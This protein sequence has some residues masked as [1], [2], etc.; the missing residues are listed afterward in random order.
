MLKKEVSLASIYSPTAEINM[1]TIQQNNQANL[2]IETEIKTNNKKRPKFLSI[3]LILKM[4][5]TSFTLLKYLFDGQIVLQHAL[6]TAPS[7]SLP[8]LT[9]LTLLDLISIIMLWLWKKNGLYLN[10]VSGVLIFSVNAFLFG[11]PL[12][13]SGIIGIVVTVLAIKRVWAQFH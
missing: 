13:L 7:W 8:A 11:L 5:V 3:L 9:A 10:V 1:N 12:A 6:S 4:I 2:S